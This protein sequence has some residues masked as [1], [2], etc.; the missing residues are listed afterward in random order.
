MSE[1]MFLFCNLYDC[2]CF[3][4]CSSV[5]C[6][7]PSSPGKHLEF[8]GQLKS[9]H[10]IF[11]SLQ[12]PNV[13]CFTAIVWCSVWR[14]STEMEHEEWSLFDKMVSSGLKTDDV[15][16]LCAIAGCD[17]AGLFE[18]E[19][20]VIE[21]MRASSEL[22]PDERHFACM[23]NLLS[24]DSFVE[25]AVKMMEH[26][27]LR[28]S[29]KACSSLLQSCNAHGKNVLGKRTANM[30]IDVGQ[31]GPATTLQVSNFFYDIGDI[32]NASR[33]KR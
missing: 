5:T 25:E 32:E 12:D 14:W 3:L 27:P 10:L 24:Q 19:R 8:N 21:L 11:E 22:D 13:I 17:Q 30:L 29:A 20:L 2:P 1:S 16:F 6:D 15:T 18:V 26:S 9:S 23:V 28:H 31:K 7:L 4:H 33:I